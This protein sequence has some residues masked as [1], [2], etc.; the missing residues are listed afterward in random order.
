MDRRDSQEVEQ[1]QAMETQRDEQ[2]EMAWV[3]EEGKLYR[4]P[5]KMIKE[6]K[7]TDLDKNELKDIP[8]AARLQYRLLLMDSVLKAKVA[9]H[10]GYIWIL[11]NPV[12]ADNTKEKISHEQLVQFLANEGVHVKPEAIQGRDYDYY[13]E[14]YKYTYFSPSIREAPPYG[15]TREQWKAEKERKEKEEYRMEHPTTVDKIRWKVFGKPKAKKSMK[16]ISLH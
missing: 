4:M 2:K 1:Q 14:Y 8:H 16:G 13:K 10:K 15:W 7:F 6:V 11:Y 12:G 9:F 5:Y 3:E